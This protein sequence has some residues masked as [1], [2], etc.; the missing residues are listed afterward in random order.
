MV[1]QPRAQPL[2]Q[3]P[4]P[5]QLPPLDA[6]CE[7]DSDC[8]PGPT[9]CPI[10]CNSEVINVKD[11]QKAQERLTCPKAQQCASAGGCRTFQYLCV[12]KKCGLFF[13]GDTGYRKRGSP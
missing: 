11:A 12:Q 5:P 7:S 3:E 8:T 1:E 2:A 9:C 6:S 4:A 13:E 10:P